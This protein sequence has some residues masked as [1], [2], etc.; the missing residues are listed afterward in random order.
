MREL[1][2]TGGDEGY[3]ATTLVETPVQPEILV[4]SRESYI[5]AMGY[6]SAVVAPSPDSAKSDMCS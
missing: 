4:H 5:T 3:S 6:V 2:T 1:Y